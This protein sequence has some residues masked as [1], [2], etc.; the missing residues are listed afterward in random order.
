MSMTHWATT[1]YMRSG[2]RLQPCPEGEISLI[3]DYY[4]GSFQYKCLLNIY[5][6]N[7]EKVHFAKAAPIFHSDKKV[8]LTRLAQKV[9]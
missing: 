1:G 7:R 8:A 4:T 2:R 3:I 9:I 6:F 5:L